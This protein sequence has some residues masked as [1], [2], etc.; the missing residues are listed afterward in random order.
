MP[1]K[2]ILIINGSASAASSNGRLI[3]RLVKAMERDFGITLAP[4]LKTI[5]HFDPELSTGDAPPEVLAWRASVETADGVIICTPE[6]IFSIPSGLKNV[7]E[8]CVA[9]TVFSDKKVGIITA[10]AS[11][12]KGHE[13]LQMILRTMMAKINEGTTWLI[14]GI[15]GKMDGKGEITDEMTR[16][17][18]DQFADAFRTFVLE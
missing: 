11:G 18:F 16:Q 17:A 8:W 6:Y 4:D 15:K 7:L 12:E 9:T 5:P 2:N 3:G 14:P 1:K 10:S 13:E